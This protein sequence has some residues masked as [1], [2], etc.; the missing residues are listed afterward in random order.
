MKKANIQLEPLACPSCLLKIQN[1]LKRLT[2]VDK[3]SIKVMY[4]SSKAR[5]DFDED[6]VSIT[7]I[8]KAI[9]KLGYNVIKS[10]VK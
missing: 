8:E 7:Q 6:L 10:T 5:L 2:G 1:A 4:N 9:T 3:K